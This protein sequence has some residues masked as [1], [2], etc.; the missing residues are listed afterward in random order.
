LLR[1]VLSAALSAQFDPFTCQFNSK[2]FY[3][4]VDFDAHDAR[5]DAQLASFI[6]LSCCLYTNIFAQSNGFL[7]FFECAFF[8]A[9]Q[10]KRRRI[11]FHLYL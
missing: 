4:I 8:I 11:S 7:T 9:S 6:H 2:G 10:E 5:D 3:V 1:E